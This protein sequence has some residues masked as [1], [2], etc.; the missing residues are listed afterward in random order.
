MPQFDRLA[1][2]YNPTIK[3]SRRER[4]YCQVVMSAA[5]TPETVLEVGGGT[6]LIASCFLGSARRIVVLDPSR[7]MLR[8]V[9]EGIERVEGVAQKIPFPDRS[10]DLVLCVDSLHHFPN[11]HPDTKKAINQAVKEMLR[12][13]KPKGTLIIIDF[14]TGR[15]G[16]KLF[17]VLEEIVW[18]RGDRF[19]SRK[20]IEK[21]FGKHG[22][23]VES[24]RLDWLSYIAKIRK[25]T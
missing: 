19:Y 6:G 15:I 13:L 5:G 2:V 18:G 8:R 17:S 25:R 1:R 10:F 9:P 21:L 12:V 20:G 16:G 22:A 24:S 3:L 11:G 14:D 23:K 4:R 7:E